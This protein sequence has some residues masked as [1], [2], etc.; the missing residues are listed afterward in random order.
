MTDDLQN[1]CSLV[2]LV[3]IGINILKKHAIRSVVLLMI[4]IYIV[5]LST[6]DPGQL[7]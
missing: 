2:I 4:N 1:G 7:N 3:M 5:S 6:H